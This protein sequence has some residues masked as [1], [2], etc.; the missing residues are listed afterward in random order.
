MGRDLGYLLS[1]HV[2]LVQEEDN[3]RAPEPLRMNDTTKEY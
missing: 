2:H 3:R 1:E